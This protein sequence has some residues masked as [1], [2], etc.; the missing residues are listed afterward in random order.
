[1][2]KAERS[3]VFESP[4]VNLDDLPPGSYSA[5]E[6]AAH[7]N[8]THPELRASFTYDKVLIEHQIV[9]IDYAKGTFGYLEGLIARNPPGGMTLNQVKSELIERWTD[10]NN[11][12]WQKRAQDAERKVDRQ[13]NELGELRKKVVELTRAESSW[14]ESYEIAL[15]HAAKE[16]Q[17]AND[18]ADKMTELHDENRDVHAENGRLRRALEKKR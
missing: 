4:N 16:R 1:M 3:E 8:K 18:L 9:G 12:S 17:R 15:S 6:V 13:G 10:Q 11:P 7:I 14:R 5:A 2:D